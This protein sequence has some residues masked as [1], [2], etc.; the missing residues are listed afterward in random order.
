MFLGFGLGGEESE[1]IPSKAQANLPSPFLPGLALAWATEV[2]TDSSYSL[3]SHP[4]TKVELKEGPPSFTRTCTRKGPQNL[5]CETWER[6]RE[7][8]PVSACS[9][10]AALT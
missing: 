9:D 8:G 5:G 2:V 3:P 4:G 10:V 6:F 1:W 7:W